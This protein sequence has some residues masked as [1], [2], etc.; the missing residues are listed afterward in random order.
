MKCSIQFDMHGHAADV[1]LQIIVDNNLIR[2]ICFDKQSHQVDFDVDNDSVHCIQLCMVNKTAAHTKIDSDGNILSDVHAIV[3]S[4]KFDQIE[5]IELF[6]RGK[7]CYQH[8]NN[9]STESLI[10]QF[11]GFIGCN[12]TVSLDFYLPIHQWF[13]EHAY[14]ALVH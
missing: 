7:L 13:V 3:K 5:V 10:D 2:R 14:D 9:G 1:C 11:Y 6:C 8:N 4:I 12:G